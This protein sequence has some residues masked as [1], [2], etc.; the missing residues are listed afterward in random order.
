MQKV[1]L[2][3]EPTDGGVRVV[4]NGA[5]RKVEHCVSATA[6]DRIEEQASRLMERFETGIRPLMD[7]VALRE[8]GQSLHDTYL[9]P[10]PGGAVEFKDDGPGQVLVSSKLPSFLN[11]PWELLPDANGGLLAEATQWTIRRSHRPDL[12]TAGARLVAPPLRILFTACAPTDQAGLDYEREE[13]AILRIADRLGGLVHLE[14]AETGTFGELGDLIS[15]LK[16]HVVHLSGHGIMRNGVGHFAFEDERGKSD[17]RDAH[18]VAR[19]LFAGHGVRL[20]FVSGCQSG[21]AGAAGVCQA[22]VAEGHVPLVVGWGASIA[23]SLATEFARVFF[24]ELASGVPV[25]QA[26]AK[27]RLALFARCRV[28]HGAVDLLDASFALPR[29]YAAEES[30]EL[31]DPRLAP[32]RPARPGVRYELLGDNIRGLR[33]GFVGRRRVLQ[34]T[35]PAMQSGKVHVVLLTGIGGAGKSTLATRLANR[36]KQDGFRVVALH[37]GHVQT[38]PF[39]L[40]LVGEL[41]TACQRLGREGDER[42]L[43]DGQRPLGE[44]LRLAV[45]VLNEAKLLLVLDNLEELMPPPPAAPV[46]QDAEFAAFF[47]DLTSRLTG[48]GRAILTCRYVPDGFDLRQPNLAHEP[49]P[50]FTEADFLKYLRR[51]D[52]VAER[53]ERGELRPELLASFYRKLGGTPRFVEQAAALLGAISPDRLEEQLERLAAPAACAPDDELKRLQQEYFSSLFLPQLYES[54]PAQSRLALSRLAVVEAPLPLDG[55]ARVAALCEPDAA[56]VLEQWLQRSLAQRFGE[57]TETP[58]YAIY[59]LQRSFLT[60]PARLPAPS[61]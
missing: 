53:I 38:L 51:H 24:H 29:L 6:Q 20:V 34:R 10:F 61:R 25:D 12:P 60:D 59:P 18:E 1:G 4:A 41:A 13:E 44:R 58:L 57:E 22:L 3:F 26:M 32:E 40:R 31:L 9:K 55:V 46:W 15:E 37:A 56:A 23:D 21:Q 33:E 35:R 11:L 50:D 2:S 19:Q 43:R 27:A 36:A 17:S 5:G 7:P 47:Q 49:M 39:G 30:N 16:P 54:L 28:R 45:E 48:E 52:R 8:L 14:I 42:L